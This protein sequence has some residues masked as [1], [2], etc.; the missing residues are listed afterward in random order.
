MYNI[1][2]ILEL[3]KQNPEEKFLREYE[4]DREE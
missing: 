1:N 3:I 4:F 2:D